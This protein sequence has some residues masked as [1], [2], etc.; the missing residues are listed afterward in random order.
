M[1]HRARIGVGLGEKAG[2]V[3]PGARPAPGTTAL[4]RHIDPRCQAPLG[5]GFLRGSRG[6]GV[7]TPQS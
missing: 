2:T 7:G 3:G 5:K 6:E 1:C 4:W